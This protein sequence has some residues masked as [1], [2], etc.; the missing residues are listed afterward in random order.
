MIHIYNKVEKEIKKCSFW[1][2]ID[3]FVLKGGF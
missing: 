1:E 2:K 3:F